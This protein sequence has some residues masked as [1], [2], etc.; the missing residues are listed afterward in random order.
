M[1]TAVQITSAHALVLEL[2]IARALHLFQ[3]DRRIEL[4]GARGTPRNTAG[5]TQ[6]I[7][8][9]H[10]QKTRSGRRRLHRSR[11]VGRLCNEKSLGRQ[12]RVSAEARV[13][14]GGLRGARPRRWPSH[15]G[16]AEAR[17]TERG[18]ALR[19]RFTLQY[20]YCTGTVQYCNETTAAF[21]HNARARART[22]S[23]PPSTG[24]TDLVVISAARRRSR[25]APLAP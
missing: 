2:H 21:Q 5:R 7:R 3:T 20:R 22:H 17:V 10:P 16:S 18:I 11:T 24:I 8:G 9:H 14:L 6:H 4:S 19:G 23:G 1:E 13:R 25:V 12:G 15:L